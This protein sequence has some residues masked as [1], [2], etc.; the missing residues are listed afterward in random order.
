M[1]VTRYLML[2]FA[3]LTLL[4]MGLAD[5]FQDG[6]PINGCA[7]PTP[8]GLVQDR[9]CDGVDDFTDNC[10]YTPNT[11]QHDSNRNGIGDVCDLL[12]TSINLEPG[13]EVKQ[14]TF[15]T[16]KIPAD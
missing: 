8:N 13:T 9:D 6:L 2:L 15:F 5:T 10:K 14:G 11:E 16:V 4:P 12:V 1:G 3:L 7:I